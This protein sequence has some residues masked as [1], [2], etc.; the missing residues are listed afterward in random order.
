MP[1]TAYS[2]YV[3]RI[4]GAGDT[5]AWTSAVNF[6][7]PCLAL[8]APWTDN[9]ESITI[10]TPNT[11]TTGALPACWASLGGVAGVNGTPTGTTYNRIPRSGTKTLNI[12]WSTTAG[13]GDYLYTPGINLVAG[14]PYRFSFWYLTDG[15]AGW[16]TLR[17]TVG[18]SPSAA[19]MTVIGTP[20]YATTV[21]TYTQVTAEFTPSTSGVYYFGANV[22]ATSNPWYMTFDDFAVEILC[23]AVTVNTASTTVSCAG[24][25]NG[26]ASV[27][28]SLSSY[29]FTWNNGQTGATATG[30][31]QGVYTVTASDGV[32]SAV[33][34]VTVTEP[35]AY[36]ASAA[37]ATA[38]SCNGG[39]NG[40]ATA[41]G[42]GAVSFLWNN[43]QTTATATGLAAGSYTV[44]VTNGDGCQATASV[45]LS[46][47]A[48]Y[49]ASAA[50][51]TAVSCNGG[52]NGSAT[53]SGTG[54]TSFLWN[55]GQTTATAVGLAA[56]SYT[57]TVT[58]GDG[59]QATA[60]VSLSDP[61]QL[62]ASVSGVN[63]PTGCTTNNGSATALSSG[64]TGTVSFLWSNSQNTPTAINL[65][66][67]TF[68]V[69]ATDANGC[70]ATSQVT[71]NAPAGITLTAPAATVLCNGA[72]DATVSVSVAGGTAPYTFVWDNGA[73]SQSVANVAAG[74]YSVTVT[75]NGGCVNNATVSVSQPAALLASTTA[76]DASCQ[77]CTD[78]SAVASATG[79]T[80]SFTFE[81]TDG[82]TA[83]TATGLATGSYTV[84]I[85]DANG[86]QTTATATVGFAIGVVENNNTQAAIRLFPNPTASI[87]TLENLPAQA[88]I[89]VLNALGQEIRSIETQN[90]IEQLDLSDL[91]AAT[92]YLRIQSVGAQT[93]LPVVR[94]R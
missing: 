12:N 45:S 92:Y 13:T 69:T 66:A 9:L 94:I 17:A 2:A 4:C 82:Q 51:A 10:T 35:A 3:R 19:A 57:V 6:T 93:T 28:A 83:A 49:T 48:A 73:T 76:T 18:A 40:S 20:I 21:T 46:D 31:A 52:S 62:F 25:N 37:Q 65:G 81:W 29:T 32:C 23:P 27:S 44:T 26:T 67:G 33:R 24:G 47:P 87:V 78:G 71:L 43:N 84:T 53:A 41:S 36:T 7:T 59:C 61:A 11:Q 15:L 72:A 64:G 85:T 80:G 77:T 8:N 38:V 91:P 22:W 79:G 14:Q 70:Q 1:G 75:D 30:L 5:S 86:C 16:D 55:N 90:A 60:S 63:N 58:N 56:G 54:A 68:T 34:S 50:Q 74:S 39:S 89:T 42:T 88:R